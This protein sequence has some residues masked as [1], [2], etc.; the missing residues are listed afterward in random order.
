MCHDKYHTSKRI[1]HAGDKHSKA[2]PYKRDK[3][4]SW[5]DGDA[6]V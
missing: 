3:S 5:K 6:E 1:K 4:K 2:V